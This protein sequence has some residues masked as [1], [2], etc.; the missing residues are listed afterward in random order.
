VINDF[1]TKENSEKL[2]QS[3]Q[4]QHFTEKAITA[5]KKLQKPF[6]FYQISWLFSINSYGF[7][8]EF[9]SHKTTE[10]L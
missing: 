1:Y 4:C 9:Y 8:T 2:K 7:S 6:F 10:M 5:S 3:L